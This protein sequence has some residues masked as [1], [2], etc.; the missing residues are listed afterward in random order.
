MKSFPGMWY[1]AVGRFRSNVTDEHISLTFGCKRN[2]CFKQHR[3]VCTLVEHGHPAPASSL[4]SNNSLTCCARQMNCW[5]QSVGLCVDLADGKPVYVAGCCAFTASSCLP[6]HTMS[7]FTKC[8][9]MCWW[10]KVG[11]GGY[12]R[13]AF[14]LYSNCCTKVYLC[15]SIYWLAVWSIVCASEVSSQVLANVLCCKVEKVSNKT[16]FGWTW[17]GHLST[18]IA[19]A[20][21]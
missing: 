3:R 13:D 8:L 7:M 6:H 17:C 2:R 4:W 11:G 21:D 15:E 5:P 12:W 16:C 20:N 1:N 14:I 18:R 10:E 19:C 9:R